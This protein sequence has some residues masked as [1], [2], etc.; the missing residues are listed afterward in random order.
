MK[1]PVFTKRVLILG[2]S[3]FACQIAEVIEASPYS[4]YSIMGF[5]GNGAGGR[6]ALLEMTSRPPHPML[7]PLEDLEKIVREQHP[8]RIIVVPTEQRDRM[9]VRD[10]LNLRMAGVLVEDGIEI[11]ERF[12]QKLAI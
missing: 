2:T 11:Y 12:A 5:V 7:G 9:P 1:I 3:P 10:L 6:A 8:D 4:R